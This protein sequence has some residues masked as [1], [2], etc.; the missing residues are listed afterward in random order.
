[1]AHP[2]A[3]PSGQRLRLF[4]PLHL[5]RR[6][7]RDPDGQ[8]REPAPGRAAPAAVQHRPSPQDVDKNVVAIGLSSGFVE[9]L[10]STS[11]HLIQASINKLLQHFPT[12]RSRRPT[13]RPTTAASRSTWRRSAT[14]WSCTTRPQSATTRPC[15]P[16]CA[17]CRS[18]TLAQRIELFR[19]R[20]QLVIHPDEMFTPTSWLAV[21]LGQ[22]VEPGSYLA[23]GG[24]PGQPRDRR[25][26]PRHE[27]PDRPPRRGHARPRRL[28][29]TPRH[30]G[31]ASRDGLTP[32]T[33]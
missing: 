8:S 27:G 2:P 1:M 6:R 22:G 21:L 16:M 30:A 5:G 25:R 23:A 10:E 4:Q 13:A 18:R 24:G 9:P 29:Q 33:A 20:G 26:I 12:G 7:R 31:G 28:S 11:I 3:A 17:R 14:S 32:S 15:G 19:E